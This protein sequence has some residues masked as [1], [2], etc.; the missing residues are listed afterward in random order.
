MLSNNIEISLTSMVA[1]CRPVSSNSA[2]CCH[3]DP[4]NAH[5]THTHTRAMLHFVLKVFYCLRIRTDTTHFVE[6]HS[7]T[8][9]FLRR[10]LEC[11][12][13]IC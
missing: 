9:V 5:F 11:E 6:I 10:M 3:I 12:R 1:L 7:A 2:F 13:H 8:V 4:R